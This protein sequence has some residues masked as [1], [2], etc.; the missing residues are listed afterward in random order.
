MYGSKKTRPSL[1]SP[2]SSSEQAPELS[3]NKPGTSHYGIGQDSGEATE[4]ASECAR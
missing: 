1:D 3:R 4:T 2:V